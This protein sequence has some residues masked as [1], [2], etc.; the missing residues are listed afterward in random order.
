[1]GGCGNVLMLRELQHL[2]EQL[3]AKILSF[4]LDSWQSI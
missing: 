1:M 4:A 3:L 2:Q